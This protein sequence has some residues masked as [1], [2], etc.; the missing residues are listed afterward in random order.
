MTYHQKA[1]YLQRQLL[2]PLKGSCC[3]ITGFCSGLK[4]QLLLVLLL[5]LLLLLGCQGQMSA[6]EPLD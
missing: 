2:W 3:C 4:L 5:V 6:V 1:C